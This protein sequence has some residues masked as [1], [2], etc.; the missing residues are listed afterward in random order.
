MRQQNDLGAG[1]MGTRYERARD[2]LFP[3]P[4]FRPAICR[5]VPFGAELKVSEAIDKQG[6]FLE[7]AMGIEPTTFSLGS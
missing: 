2:F 7:R 4:P 5:S 6:D 1:A 3:K